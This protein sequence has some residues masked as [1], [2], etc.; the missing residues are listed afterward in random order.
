MQ[1]VKRFREVEKKRATLLS[2]NDSILQNASVFTCPRSDAAQ[3]R[4][5]ARRFQAAL[6]AHSA[7]DEK[8]EDFRPIPKSFRVGVVQTDIQNIEEAPVVANLKFEW[9]R[10]RF[11]RPSRQKR[12]VNL[13]NA[14][15]RGILKNR[16]VTLTLK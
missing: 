5:Q 1:N 4:A 9:V 2:K 13:T 10:Q 14:T 11:E 8:I 12:G 6:S 15:F 7:A 3:N 16:S